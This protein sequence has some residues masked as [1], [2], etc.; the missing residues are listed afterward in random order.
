MASRK[1][2]IFKLE[3]SEPGRFLV[4]VIRYEMGGVN[5]FSGGNSRRG[6]YLSVTPEKHENG[7][8]SFMMFSGIKGLLQEAARFNQRILDTIEAPEELKQKLIAH[9][10]EKEKIVLANASASA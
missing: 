4:G 10:L 1:R 6:Y 3:T 8:V 7:S 9:V 2:Q 5:Y